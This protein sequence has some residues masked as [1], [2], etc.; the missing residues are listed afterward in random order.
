MRDVKQKKI[1]TVS[2]FYFV[3][4]LF[5]S[6]MC[7]SLYSSTPE[8]PRA[9]TCSDGK[10]HVI[11]L[12]KF[13]FMKVREISPETSPVCTHFLLYRPHPTMSRGSW[14]QNLLHIVN[15]FKDTCID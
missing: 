9:L 15:R 10:L 3:D 12:Q 1:F 5:H 2:M 4:F 13:P 7:D 11:M 14:L 6:F 8:F